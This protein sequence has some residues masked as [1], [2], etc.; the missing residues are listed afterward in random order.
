MTSAKRLYPAKKKKMNC[1][2]FLEKKNKLVRIKGR[3]MKIYFDD[4]KRFYFRYY[5]KFVRRLQNDAKKRR[6]KIFLL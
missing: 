3:C 5:S 6:K 4:R 2:L 1:N